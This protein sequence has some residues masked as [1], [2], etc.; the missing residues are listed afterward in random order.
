M[1][2]LRSVMNHHPR[3]YDYTTM[4]MFHFS[5]CAVSYQSI[6]AKYLVGITW[7]C[8]ERYILIGSLLLT[9]YNLSLSTIQLLY[10]IF[11]LRNCWLFTKL[12]A[13]RVSNDNLIIILLVNFQIT[14]F[15]S[16]S[17]LLHHCCLENN[18]FLGI[19]Y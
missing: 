4:N 13:P 17:A 15:C 19:N 3:Q 1:S 2:Y 9:C 7:L 12:M 6:A 10:Q 14:L 11:T 8:C 18:F 16:V 5:H